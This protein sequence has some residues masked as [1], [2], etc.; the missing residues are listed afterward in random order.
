MQANFSSRLIAVAGG[1]GSGKTTL[2]A[3]A[4]RELRAPL[5]SLDR[6]YWDLAGYPP[7][8]RGMRNFDHPEALEWPLLRRHVSCLKQG[9]TVDAP[10]YDFARHTRAAAADRVEPGRFVVIEGIHALCDRELRA[11]YDL[12]VF[13]ETSR[14]ERL[15]RR[16]SRDVEERGRTAQSR[17]RSSSAR[18]SRCTANS[19]R[20]RPGTPIWSSAAK[21]RSK[22]T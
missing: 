22:R 20:R 13:V 17:P 3:A 8:R 10:R 11:L 15:R 6:Y 12:R 9:R 2:A 21:R 19:W 4:A 5:L 7:C 1:S 16:L 14:E 18:S